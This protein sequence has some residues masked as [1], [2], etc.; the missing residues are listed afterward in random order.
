M[1][2][3]ANE[4]RRRWS[5]LDNGNFLTQLGILMFW[6]WADEDYDQAMYAASLVP[7][8]AKGN[9]E[10]FEQ[11]DWWYFYDTIGSYPE[12]KGVFDRMLV[13][14]KAG[15]EGTLSHPTPNF[16]AEEY[17]EDGTELDDA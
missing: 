12:R 15:W 8:F 10:H 9:T 4:G 17:G 14:A 3:E 7:D 5:P 2:A 16:W 11:G 6:Y 1:I 13:T